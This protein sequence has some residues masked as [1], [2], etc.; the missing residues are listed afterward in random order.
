MLMKHNIKITII[1]LLLFFAAQLIGLFITSKYIVN[2]NLPLDIERPEVDEKTSYIP[3]LI[4][5]VVATIIALLIA[6]FR[7]MKLWRFWF[8]VSVFVTLNIAF[9]PFLRDF[10]NNGVIANII[11]CGGLALWK[12]LKRNIFV[13]NLTELFIYAGLSAIFVP[14]LG[15]EA[16]SI[17]LIAIAIYD[18]I[19]VWQTKHMIRLAKFQS[20]SKLFAGLYIPYDKGK[21]A[22]LGGGDIGFPLLFAGVILKRTGTL[23]AIIVAIF[24]SLALFALLLLSKK[25]R[26]YPA[27][28][29]LAFGCFVGY[30]VSLII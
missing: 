27:M 8:F 6:R 1:I 3:L 22:I 20:E 30:F 25:N 12:T 16:V 14:I 19:A 7:A 24:A 13:H 5:I 4:M 9:W 10:G 2:G 28:P 15:L 18:I 23:D 11:I 29:F 17:L 21:E 26:F